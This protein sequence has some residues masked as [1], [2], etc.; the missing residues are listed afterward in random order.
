MCCLIQTRIIGQLPFS[1]G[2]QDVALSQELSGSITSQNRASNQVYK[3]M[4]L[5]LSCTGEYGA[6][7]GGVSQAI[8]AMNATMTRCNGVFERD[9][10]VKLL[11]IDNNDVVVYTNASTD[12]Y[13]GAATGSN[14]AWNTELMNN[15]HNTLGD[16]AFDIGHLFGASGGGGNAGCIGCVCT[17][18]LSTGGGSNSYKGAGFTSP[19]DGV[20]QGDT[21]DIDYVA[22]EM[23]HQM[24]ANHTFSHT[25]ENNSVNVEPGSGTTIMAYAGIRWNRY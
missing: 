14:G 12:P 16:D 21:F 19:A 24:G 10:A 15:L 3:T 17:N 1:C 4:R 25:N 18:V 8:A 11:M 7:F 23:G 22:H 6:Y 9:L 13:S 2:T 20:P 5:A